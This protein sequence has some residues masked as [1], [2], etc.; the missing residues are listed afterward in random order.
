MTQSELF[1]LGRSYWLQYVRLN[2]YAWEPSEKGLR[3][4]ARNLDL[5]VG[6]V[7]KAIYTYLSA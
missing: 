4:L 6:H 7:R 5:R 2:G 1:E 3:V